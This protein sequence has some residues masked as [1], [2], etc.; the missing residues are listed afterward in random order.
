MHRYEARAKSI[1]LTKVLFK[2]FIIP[3]ILISA[4]ISVYYFAL[5]LIN[6]IK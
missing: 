1:S 2:V 4:G 3:A 6:L 5:T